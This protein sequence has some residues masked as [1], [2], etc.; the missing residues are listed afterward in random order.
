M[1]FK[2]H[3]D[4]PKRRK[5]GL[6]GIIRMFMSLVMILLLLTGI[7]LAYKQFSGLD[8]LK[9]DTNSSIKTL[10]TSDNVYILINGLLS[11]DIDTIKKS[12]QNFLKSPSTGST[13]STSLSTGS[14]TTDTS[15]P[16]FFR[17]AVIADSHTDTASLQKALI[18]AKENGAELVVGLGD[19]SDVGTVDEL[20]NSKR[21]FDT[22]KLPY[23][24]TPGDHDLW[25][26]RDKSRNPLD[27]FRQVF[28]DT[29]SSFEYKGVRFLLL[30]NS[31]NYTG[32]DGVQ[33][34]WIED[35]L[36]R[37]SENKPKLTLV[38]A[39]SPLFHPSSDHVMGK[40]NPK[41][42]N[43]ARHL[44]DVFSRFGVAEVIAGDGH[45]YSRYIEPEYKLKMTVL[46]AV[47]S[48]R[49]LQA[50]RYLMVDVFEDGSY[51]IQDT[52]IK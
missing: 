52:E 16:L 15:V 6:L 43:Q 10:M 23:Y 7:Y 32:L 39:H 41:L 27:N 34:K 42:T 38:F 26:A 17:F 1:F 19:Y 44:I 50:P 35:E 13:T 20:V 24:L 36:Q 46:G 22:V 51:N 40:V 2:K 30:D 49:N 31:D 47:T 11:F 37:I 14:L 9:I 3:E 8:P 12:L 5:G 18:Q 33:L 4:K 29:Y 48:N 25:D 28:K 21:Q 45:F